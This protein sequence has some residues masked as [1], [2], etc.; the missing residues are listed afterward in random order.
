M[1]FLVPRDGVEEDPLPRSVR[2]RGSFPPPDVVA[3]DGQRKALG[4]W[5]PDKER[6]RLGGFE[7][8]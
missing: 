4:L 3:R 5:P 7:L 8:V 1:S 6:S 2:C